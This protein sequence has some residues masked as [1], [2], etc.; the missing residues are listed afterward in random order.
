MS[1]E[2]RKTAEEKPDAA[3]AAILTHLAPRYHFVP[4]PT[5]YFER[6]PFTTRL[7]YV[8]RFLS[9]AAVDNTTKQKVHNIIRHT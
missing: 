8:C 4:H 1:A 5:M 9:I 3:L 6:I 7:G 2:V